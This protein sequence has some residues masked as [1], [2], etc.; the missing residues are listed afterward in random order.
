MII[1]I[2]TD[3]LKKLKIG[4]RIIKKIIDAGQVPPDDTCEKIPPRFVEKT[5]NTT[6]NRLMSMSRLGKFPAREGDKNFKYYRL[7]KILVAYW[8]IL[9]GSDVD[10]DIK[11]QK[12]LKLEIENKRRTRELIDR[13][14]AEDRTVSLLR[15]MKRMFIYIAKTAAPVL[16]SCTNARQAE[17]I[18]M[19]RY[20]DMFAIIEQE[21]NKKEWYE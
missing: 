19:D 20:K 10:N 11:E 3:N 2:D 8:T 13:R 18:I 14:E 12:R 7:S 16:L 6:R 17:Q 21:C 1:T 4:P 15:T 5:L 9:F